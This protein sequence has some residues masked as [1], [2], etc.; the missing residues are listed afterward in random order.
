MIAAPRAWT[1]GPGLLSSRLAEAASARVTGSVSSNQMVAPATVAANNVG[2]LTYVSRLEVID[3]LGLTDR[4]IAR[5][6]G[7]AVEFPAHESHDGSYV[8]DRRP[9]II[10]YGQPRAFPMPRPRGEVLAVG[11]P[12]DRDLSRDARFLRDY[13]FDHMRLP[14]GRFVPLFR[15]A[16][17]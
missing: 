1:I 9:D 12:S 6:A 16:S 13:V 14:D 7:K 11:Y 2:V 17:D 4:H 10:F 15:L 3:M 8:L 5:A